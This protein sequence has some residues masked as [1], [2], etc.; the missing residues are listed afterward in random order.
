MLKLD[1]ISVIFLLLP[2]RSESEE[3]SRSRNYNIC[4]IYNSSER[5]GKQACSI[6]FHFPN[7]LA[8]SVTEILTF[9]L[10]YSK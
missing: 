2:I 9:L 3:L 1:N 4:S 5:R 10:T 8:S 6:C 7:L